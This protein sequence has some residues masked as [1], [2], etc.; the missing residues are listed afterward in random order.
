MVNIK[1]HNKKTRILRKTKSN[2]WGLTKILKLRKKK[3]W[4]MRRTYAHSF[5]EE[6]H[7]PV[8]TSGPRQNKPRYSYQQILRKKQNLRY[9]YGNLKEV[10][11]K[12]LFLNKKNKINQMDAIIQQLESRLDIVLF[13]MGYVDSIAEARQ[14]IKHK[15]ILVNGIVTYSYNFKVSPND[16]ISLDP[17]L[18]FFIYDKLAYK[19]LYTGFYLAFYFMR[20]MKC[21]KRTRSRR[22]KKALKPFKRKQSVIFTYFI[23]YNLKPMIKRNFFIKVKPKPRRFKI[24]YK[25]YS[26]YLKN[27]NFYKY[28][29]RRYFFLLNQMWD[30]KLKYKKIKR[31]SR[32]QLRMSRK[33]KRKPFKK[34]KP[35][36]NNR[37]SLFPYLSTVPYVL[38]NFQY[39]VGI[40]VF[41]PTREYV[42]FFSNMEFN[43]VQRY[44]NRIL[45]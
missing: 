27:N 8:L 12:K 35:V 40:F 13:R 5:F 6:T 30:Y 42:P 36:N 10:Q 7:S 45:I 38:V 33:N 39:L 41:R 31:L 21:L 4:Y 3:W 22:R 2:F 20:E 16:I 24:V 17:Q 37:I 43:E 28:K 25:K 32:H 15:K 9:Y 29:N 1:K 19:L 34:Y 11:F 26:L 18:K 23:R 44:Y 14:L